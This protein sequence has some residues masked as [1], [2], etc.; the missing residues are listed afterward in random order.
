[1]ALLVVGFWPTT[2]FPDNYW[3]EDFW[4]DYG[5]LLY[6]TPRQKFTVLSRVKKFTVLKT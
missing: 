6:A 3:H 5:L 2:F 4:Q 1:M